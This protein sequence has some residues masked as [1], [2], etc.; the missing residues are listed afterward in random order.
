MKRLTLFPLVAS[1]VVSGALAQTTSRNPHEWHMRATDAPV[2]I[3]EH[4]WEYKGNPNIAIIVGARAA[5][6][7]DTG[8][9]PKYGAMAAG[10][11]AKLAPGKRLYLTTTHFH[12]EHAAGDSGFP[13]N[14]LLIRNDV[15]QAQ[16]EHDGMA[17]VKFFMDK[18]AENR[19]LLKDVKFRT[20]DVTFHT[21]ARVD[22]GGGVTVRLLWLGPAHTEGDELIFVDPDATLVSGD[23][24]QNKTIPI[25][26]TQIG[27]GGT[28]STWIKVVDKLEALHAKH[29]VPDHSEPGDGSLVV[30]ERDLL[31]E[32][33]S[34]ALV[35]RKNNMPAEK[36]GA[37]ISA[38]LKQEHPDWFSTDVSDFVKKVYQ[39]P[40]TSLM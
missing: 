28:P 17:M 2:R 34:A 6:V 30:A 16:V 24:V 20:P 9:G 7:V 23:V 39:D 8:M 3:S 25:I 18:S 10:F 22:L 32:I 5:M 14:T 35:A 13:A 1:L 15:Q 31:D 11:A 40:D 37:D 38:K 12:P 21:E 19:D 26:F 4:V 36:A 27:K 33:R 29:V